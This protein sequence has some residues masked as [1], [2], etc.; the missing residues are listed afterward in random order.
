MVYVVA[1]HSEIRWGERLEY[2]AD[3]GPGDFAYFAP[4]VP[5]QERNPSD[6]EP[7]VFLVV[8]SEGERIAVKLDEKPVERPERVY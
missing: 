5:H 6:T 4:F 8:R 1:G 3:I 2:V 7:F